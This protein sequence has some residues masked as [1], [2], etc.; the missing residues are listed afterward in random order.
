MEIVVEELG[1][2]EGKSNTIRYQSFLSQLN[3]VSFQSKHLYSCFPKLT[4]ES[5]IFKFISY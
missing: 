1:G 5:D 2:P 4:Y 3:V